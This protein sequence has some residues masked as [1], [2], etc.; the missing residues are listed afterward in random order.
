MHRI[1]AVRVRRPAL[2]DRPYFGPVGR[3]QGPCRGG[4]LRWWGTASCHASAA[5]GRKGTTGSSDRTY[6]DLLADLVRPSIRHDGYSAYADASLHGR[7]AA[8]AAV[9]YAG[10]RPVRAA[11]GAGEAASIGDAETRAILL[12]ARLLE[13]LAA[14]GPIYSDSR[15]A[16]EAAQPL[17][18]DHPGVTAVLWTPQETNRAADVLSKVTRQTW[19]G[20]RKRS[21]R[22]PLAGSPRADR[23]PAPASVLR[24]IGPGP[25][26]SPDARRGHVPDPPTLETAIGILAAE[27]PVPVRELASRIEER[28][29]NLLAL[30]GRPEHSVRDA[31]ASLRR[32]GAIAVDAAADLVRA[33][34]EQIAPAPEREGGASP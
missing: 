14:N 17:I 8:W 1:T 29:P 26:A 34:P 9:A 28:W 16:V 3:R 20:V 32:K 18:G 4:G 10:E 6:T 12:A 24:V 11:V 33:A 22:P 23:P 5:R 27:Q 15:E 21:L 13:E 30:R 25:T 7:D 19:Q 31:V 2:H